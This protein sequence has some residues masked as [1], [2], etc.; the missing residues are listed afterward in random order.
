MNTL[1]QE[2]LYTAAGRYRAVEDGHA[3]PHR[4]RCIDGRITGAGNCVGF[5]H[6]CEH[7]GYLT[8]ELRKEHDCIKKACCHYAPKERNSRREVSPFAVL[9]E[10]C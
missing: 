10:Y 7:P 9:L 3:A 5:C 1:Q 8:K 4:R 6:Y 2:I